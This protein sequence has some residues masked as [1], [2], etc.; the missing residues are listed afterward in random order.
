[1]KPPFKIQFYRDARMM[2]DSH[3]YEVHPTEYQSKP[4]AEGVATSLMASYSKKF[5]EH[6]GYVIIDANETVVHGPFRT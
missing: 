6:A 5:G 3:D 2:A 4:E 1:M